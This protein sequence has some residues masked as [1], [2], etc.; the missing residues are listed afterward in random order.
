[1]PELGCMLSILAT[2]LQKTTIIA[3]SHSSFLFKNV[4]EIGR[5]PKKPEWLAHSET[6]TSKV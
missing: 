6:D 3:V 4:R 2:V 5:L 1:M